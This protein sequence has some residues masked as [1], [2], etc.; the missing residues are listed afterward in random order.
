MSATDLPF[1][2]D[3]GPITDE[4]QVRLVARTLLRV[5]RRGHVGQKLNVPAIARKEGGIPVAGQVAG[6]REALS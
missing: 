6:L 3:S 1:D 5:S 2:A 4:T